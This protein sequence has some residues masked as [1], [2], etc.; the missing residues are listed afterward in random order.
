MKL[1]FS[2][3]PAKAG[4][5]LQPH[6]RGWLRQSGSLSLI[7]M[8]KPLQ[9]LSRIKLPSVNSRGQEMPLKLRAAFPDTGAGEHLPALLAPQ[10]CPASGEAP[11]GAPSQLWKLLG[12]GYGL[13]AQA[14]RVCSSPRA[15]RAWCPPSS[16]SSA[17]PP[18]SAPQHHLHP[19]HHLHP[20][21]SLSFSGALPLGPDL[22]TGLL[23]IPM[24]LQ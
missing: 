7:Y 3:T 17:S 18:S 24:E 16:A 15:T 2:V 13:P 5:E 21:P 12:S 10:P 22:A 9:P 19:H 1:T 14:P 6:Y 23:N 11:W 8:R 4:K 20:L